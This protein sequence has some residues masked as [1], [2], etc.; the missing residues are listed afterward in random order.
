MQPV[1][2]IASML[3]VA[4]VDGRAAS[5]LGPTSAPLVQLADIAVEEMTPELRPAFVRG[6]QEELGARGY[7]VGTAD[8]SLG[9]RTRAAILDYQRDA[10]LAPTGKAS[11][12][13]LDHLK[14]ALPRVTG[15]G[16]PAPYPPTELIRGIQGELARRGYYRGTVDGR[17]GPA[18]RGAIRDFQQ[19][20]GLP[21][22]G[23]VDDRLF[24]ELKLADPS[25]RSTRR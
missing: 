4:S 9:P 1:R 14:F 19:D 7:A 6:I 11:K 10:G 8:G 5:A 3:A 22:T 25:I 16:M 23:T 18:T 24:S 13:L 20:A 17:A 15:P 21:V 12:D 2:L